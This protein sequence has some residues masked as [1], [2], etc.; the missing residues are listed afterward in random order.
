MAKTQFNFRAGNAIIWKSNL[1]ARVK[2]PTLDWQNLG[3][4]STRIVTNVAIADLIS[5]MLGG[6]ATNWQNFK[7]H[8]SGTG[9]APESASDTA[10]GLEV[11]SRDVGTQ[12]TPAAG[13]YETVA[14]HT[15]SG[16]Y[17]ISEH[18]LFSQLLG[19]ILFDRSVFTPIAVVVG[20]DIEWT[21]TL[22]ITGA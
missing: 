19:G 2:H 15:Y 11:E 18:G 22:T 9:S 16:S 5:I 3:I 8:A 1:S 13:V 17:N 6:P 20:T 4:L 12:T 10:L 14:T 7:F 21:Y